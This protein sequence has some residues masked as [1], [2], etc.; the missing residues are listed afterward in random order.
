MNSN[1]SGSGDA[2]A[3]DVQKTSLTFST[4][5]SDFSSLDMKTKVVKHVSRIKLDNFTT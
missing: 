2:D 5:K 4:I 1:V 3:D